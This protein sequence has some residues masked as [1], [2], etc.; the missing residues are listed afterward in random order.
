MCCKK[1][2]IV[3]RQFPYIGMFDHEEP[4]VINA[5]QNLTARFLEHL[6]IISPTD[7]DKRLAY[8]QRILR[9]SVL[10]KYRNPINVQAV[11]GRA[12]G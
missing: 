8:M 3:K 5:M 9:G 4:M 1:Q 2:N 6:D 7:V 12:R 11:N 10:K